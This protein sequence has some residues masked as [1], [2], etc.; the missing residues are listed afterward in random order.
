MTSHMTSI[1]T[2]ENTERQDIEDDVNKFLGGY[3]NY[4]TTVNL[5]TFIKNQS[6]T[7]LAL[8]TIQEKL[9]TIQEK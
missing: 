8:V 3:E 2:F 9:V 5:S 4:S 1:K 6:P 7:Y